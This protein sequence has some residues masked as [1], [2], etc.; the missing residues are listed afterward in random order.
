MNALLK[1]HNYFTH[2]KMFLQE[3][4][5]SSPNIWS[6]LAILHQWPKLYTRSNSVHFFYFLIPPSTSL[7]RLAIEI[8]SSNSIASKVDRRPWIGRIGVSS[9]A[10]QRRQR[11]QRELLAVIIATPRYISFPAADQLEIGYRGCFVMVV[12]IPCTLVKLKRIWKFYM[13]EEQIVMR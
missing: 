10:V 3:P 11:K 4:T 12:V 7:K 2:H 1:L 6:R 8:A 5:R 9:D 13:N